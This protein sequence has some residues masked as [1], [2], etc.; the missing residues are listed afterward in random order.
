METNEETANSKHTKHIKVQYFC[1]KDEIKQNKIVLA[2]C[3][4]ET[5]WSDAIT[6]PLQGVNS[7]KCR[8]I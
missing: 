4:N 1:I 3:P 2:Y 8:H 6:K 7:V 5:M